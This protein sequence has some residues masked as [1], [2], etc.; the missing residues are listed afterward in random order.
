MGLSLSPRQILGL[1]GG[2]VLLGLITAGVIHY[3][4]LLADREERDQLAEWQLDIR[5][6][7]SDAVDA[8]TKDGERG[9]LAADQIRPQIEAMGA[10]IDDLQGSIEDQNSDIQARADDLAE[11]LEREQRDRQRLE[12]EARRGEALIERLR[13]EAEQ[14]GDERCLAPDDFIDDL[15]DL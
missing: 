15:G 14:P 8:K 11:R 7:V 10:S 3:R 4:G 12:R 2:I 9:L 5:R 13:R 6:A 1:I